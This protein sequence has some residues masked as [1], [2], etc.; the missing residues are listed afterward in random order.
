MDLMFCLKFGAIF[1]G[2]IN[3]GCALYSSLVEHPSRLSSGTVVGVTMFKKA[4]N[5]SSL[6]SSIFTVFGLGCSAYLLILTKNIHWLFSGISSAL[7]IPISL[8]LIMPYDRVLNDDKVLDGID[9]DED[10]NAVVSGTMNTWGI[11]NGLRTIITLI[12]FLIPIYSVVN[13]K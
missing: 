4:Y 6:L 8:L 9:K 11:L 10:K 2:G 7:T 13:N 3:C 1:F 5:T 12:S